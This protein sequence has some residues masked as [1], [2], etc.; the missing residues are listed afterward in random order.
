MIIAK[1][2][3][4]GPFG[5]GGMAPFPFDRAET[6]ITRNGRTAIWLGL[7]ALGLPPQARIL[8][9]A[10]HCGS[11][12]DAILAA[13][14]LPVLY[15]LDRNLIVDPD[16][17]DRL[18]GQHKAAAIYVIHY[19]GQAQPL[20]ALQQIAMRHG[21]PLIE[22]LALGLYSSGPQEASLGLG[23]DMAVFSLVKTIATPDGGALWLKNP[24]KM[25]LPKLVTPPVRT[26][27][28][29]TKA[30]LM[31]CNR[32]S[33]HDGLADQDQQ[34]RDAWDRH[35]GFEAPD[36]PQSASLI[37]KTIL[38]FTDHRSLA[39]SRRNTYRAIHAAVPNLPHLHPLFAQLSLGACP[40]YFPLWAQQPEKLIEAFFQ[41]GIEAVR[42]W[43]RFHPAFDLHDFPF[44]QALKRQVIRLPLH[45]LVNY[46]A[47]ARIAKACA[48]C[49]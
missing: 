19:F 45:R 41:A 33:V 34:S 5:W 12:I 22:D 49:A 13:G 3:P 38:R 32:Q 9:P 29:A 25:A 8:V 6:L 23:S 10:W 1:Q 37:S 27:L 11:E 17:I 43:R 18:L 26:T 16:Q 36:F 21:V 48:T 2:P 46:D 28:P 40:A 35:A 20:Q 14:A 15:G 24:P 39:Q 42:F 30:L 4:L 31:N 47:V 44:E 7:R